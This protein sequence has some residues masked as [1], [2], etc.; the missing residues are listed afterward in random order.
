M[1][2]FPATS[3]TSIREVHSQD[4]AAARQ[5]LGDLL[6]EYASPVVA[7][8]RR[9]GIPEGE[10]EDAAQAFMARFFVEGLAEAAIDPAQGR[11]RDYLRGALR[12]FLLNWRAQERCA[13]RRPD[14]PVVSLDAL[15]NSSGSIPIA[16]SSRT[17]E[18]AFDRQWAREILAWAVR[19]TQEE[20]EADGRNDRWQVFRRLVLLH[21][22]PP[23]Y[24]QVADELGT[25]ESRVTNALHAAKEVFAR[26][27][28]AVVAA[29]VRGDA[30]TVES[31]LRDLA[32]L[33]R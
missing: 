10:A 12:H 15:R 25:T 8:T 23:S 24:R 18:E 1:P 16:D 32:A 2:H 7:Y 19:A 27:L 3:W 20:L 5:A 14:R 30:A 11:F 26:A 22:P 17:P 33:F 28:R 13:R 9:F 21:G 6:H 31:E 29:T 4:P